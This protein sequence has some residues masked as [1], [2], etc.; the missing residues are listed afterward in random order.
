MLILSF[1]IS[2]A[3]TAK[4]PLAMKCMIVDPD[5]RDR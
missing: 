2:V 5:Q 4:K 3:Q 1:Q